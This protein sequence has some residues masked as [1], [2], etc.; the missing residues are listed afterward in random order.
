MKLK[1]LLVGLVI[2][3][4]CLISAQSSYNSYISLPDH[5]LYSSHPVE[6]PRIATELAKIET[7]GDTL[8]WW[9]GSWA[10][11]PEYPYYRPL[12]SLMWWLEYK[13][14][15]ANGL[16]GFLIIHVLLHIA[17][18]LTL[19]RFLAELFN[20]R[21][22]AI[23]A[24]I[25][26]SNLAWT[27]FYLAVPQDSMSSWIDDPEM[28]CSMSIVMA[29][30]CYLRYLRRNDSKWLFFSLALY[31]V[32]ILWKESAYVV[33][34]FATLL[35]WHEKQLKRWHSALPFAAIT[36]LAFAYRTWALQGM[37]FQFGTNGS[38]WQ[39]AAAELLGGGTVATLIYGDTLPLLLMLWCASAVTLWRREWVKSAALLIASAGAYYQ[40]QRYASHLIGMDSQLLRLMFL[41]AWLSA[42][43]FALLA[44]FAYRFVTKR[45]RGQIF[46]YGWI[47]CAYLPLLKGVFTPHALYFVA[48]GWALFLA[49]A[50]MDFAQWPVA[51][52]VLIKSKFS[53]DRILA[54]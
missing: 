11:G 27:L 34:F 29:L 20:E 45:T 35:L 52:K 5:S 10:M 12:T 40:L 48:A 46:A 26:A 31:F 16:A 3:A 51:R 38:W 7:I 14:F 18:V 33:P 4:L 54:S 8:K 32:A 17:F 53:W 9:T 43:R 13:A 19:W 1:L 28:T 23:T 42:A 41:D 30:W 15:G 2:V 39:R 25:F 44:F 49:H 37:G 6:T 36:V 21:I 22:A 24:C 47:L 50:F